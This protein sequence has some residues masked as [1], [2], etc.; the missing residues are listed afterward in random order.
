[1]INPLHY[2]IIQQ[3]SRCICLARKTTQQYFP[4]PSI[5]FDIRGKTA[6][7]ALLQRWQLRFNPILLAE[8]PHAFLH[9]VV[10]HEVSHL[11][12]YALFNKVS[13]HGKEWQNIMKSIFNQEP[14]VT[15]NFNV[16]SVQEKTIAYQCLCGPVDL[17]IRRHNKIKRH[18]IRYICRKCKQALTISV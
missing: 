9:Q 15:H 6:G 8:N 12:V 1:M 14:T 17:S 7:M 2:Q 16:R 18:N 10:P 11:I 3:V 5:R 13:P 4:I